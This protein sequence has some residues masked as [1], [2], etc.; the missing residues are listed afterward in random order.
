MSKTIR[1]NEED[2]IRLYKILTTKRLANQKRGDLTNI[3][4]N[5]IINEILNEYEENR[6]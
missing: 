3:G 5:D 2:Y 1:I 4:Y 6:Q